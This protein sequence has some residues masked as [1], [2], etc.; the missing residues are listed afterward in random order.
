[1][2][3]FS[4]KESDKFHED[5]RKGCLGKIGSEIKKLWNEY[6]IDTC[7]A[8][9]ELFKK[10]PHLCK[11]L[12][13]CVLGSEFGKYLDEQMDKPISRIAALGYISIGVRY[14]ADEGPIIKSTSKATYL[15]FIDWL[16]KNKTAGDLEDLRRYTLE[17][18]KKYQEMLDNTILCLDRGRDHIILRDKE[19]TVQNVK[20]YKD[21]LDVDEAAFNM[22]CNENGWTVNKK[23]STVGNIPLCDSKRE[24]LI[25]LCTERIKDWVN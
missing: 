4:K 6:I 18:Y 8:I 20:T 23:V 14:N 9:G 12:K 22:I 11:T 1:M 24:E 15:E 13:I 3:F 21:L 16:G 5:V 10:A 7:P 17:Y 19:G 25:T 2:R